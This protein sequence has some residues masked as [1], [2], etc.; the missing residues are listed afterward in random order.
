[1]IDSETEKKSHQCIVCFFS[2]LL[3]FL[4]LSAR[5]RGVSKADADISAE[6]D[7]DKDNMCVF[8]HIGGNLTCWRVSWMFFLLLVW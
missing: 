2:L 5:Y 1:M 6:K 8:R 3:L 4:S 7:R